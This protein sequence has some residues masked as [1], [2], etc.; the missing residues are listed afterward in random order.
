MAKTKLTLIAA[1]C[2]FLLASCDNK[3]DFA[4]PPRA[5]DSI[6]VPAQNSTIAV[7]VE[8]DLSNL[9]TQLSREIPRTLWRIN[10]PNQ[11]CVP[12]EKV[13]IAFV[14]IK[15]PKIECDIVG[16]VTRGAMTIDG[17]GQDIVVT[18]PI[19]AEV[20]ARDIGGVLKQETATGDATV[21]AVVRLSLDNQW[22]PRGKVN[23]EYDWTDAPHVEFLGQRI[24]FTSEADE[25]LQGV[26]AR[27]E[28]TLPR[29]LAKLG[30]RQ[31]IEKLWGQA[32]TSLQLNRSDPPVWMRVTPQRLKYGGYTL[33]GKRL[34]LDL[35]MDART[36]TFVG[37]KPPAPERKPLPA[38]ARLEGEPGG[39]L[40]FIP[41]IADYDQLEPVIAK[42]LVKRS[43]R[44]FDVPG[45]GLVKARFGE[46]EAYGT[47][48]NRIAVGVTFAA[49]R[50][51]ER[52]G[53]AEGRVWLTA[54][55]VNEAGSRKVSFSDL[56]I[57]GDTDR[58]STD[59]LLDIA[60]APG[61]AQTIAVAL[62]QNF[63]GDYDELMTKIR[64]AIDTTREGDVIIHA[65][66]EDVKTGELKAA[67]QG[68]YLPV[69]GTGTASVELSPR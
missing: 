33:R 66:I 10:Q 37:D 56:E 43:A 16:T 11:T 26:I 4:P 49:A 30:L 40:F 61:F 5:D 23:I 27:L 6:E 68:L 32:F 31:E 67:G 64:N 3:P 41:V 8:A 63:E 1:T 14:K 39:M 42:A 36:E 9:A 48:D 55:P 47:T 7:P 22:N 20:Q 15:T 58:E 19:H 34:E 62:A 53:D 50:V 46:V 17:R 24:E 35:G 65:K 44:P 54:T 38:M 18:M 28:R 2:A 59:F 25:K 13:K 52:F 51:D 21:R 12:S 45:I 60:N 57:T 69:W 29:E